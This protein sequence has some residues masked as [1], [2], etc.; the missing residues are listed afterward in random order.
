VSRRI[1][2]G[3]LLAVLLVLMAAARAD[4]HAVPQ[5]SSPADRSHLDT[6]PTSVSVTFNESV[7]TSLGGM[8]VVNCDGKQVDDGNVLARDNT[9]SVGI[10]GTLGN[11]AYVVAW[12]VISA[13]S[14]PVRGAFTFVVGQGADASDTC[15]QKNFSADSERLLDATGTVGRSLGYVGVFLAAGG[16][17]FLTLIHDGAAV[18]RQLQRIV[19]GA[20]V[21]GA[22]GVLVALPIE[23]DLAT[24]LGLTAITKGGVLSDVLADGV[25]LSTVLAL[26]GLAVLSIG[27]LKPRAR[28]ARVMTIAGAVLAPLSFAFAGHTTTTSP[29]L[30]V[31]VADAVH[32][33]AGAAWFG[34]LTFLVLTLL[35]RGKQR[36]PVALGGIVRR[37]SLIA[38]VGVLAVTIAGA[39]LGWSQVR[40][41]RALTST[42]YGR[43]LMVKVALVIPIALIGAYNHF[44]L[45]P[46]IQQ[47]A[48]RGR[49]AFRHLLRTVRI[50]SIGLVVVLVLTAA[51]VNT[52]PARTAAGIGTIFSET[53]PIGQDSVNLVVDPNRAGGNSIHLYLLDQS[54]R[55]AALAQSVELD[56]SLPSAN[57]GPI[58]RNPSVAG[59]GHY[60][61]D[62]NDL[63]IA[64][65]WT[66]VVRAQ[67]SKFEEN[68][69]NFTVNVNP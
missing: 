49:D 1:A 44:R 5:A 65:A 57:I 10:D 55:P 54:G 52:P 50:E 6:P 19:F 43:I 67:V 14:H 2:Y 32:L 61:L 20:A 11:G 3:A 62:S 68:T 16:A 29:Q 35:R 27:L 66:I 34:G 40:A 7:S 9:V 21:I 22:F 13:D 23:A 28:W 47:A 41:W 59:P 31:N 53:K 45:V 25:G 18:R 64:G 48:A 17:L 69:A 36:D 58:V 63:T 38:T 24:G 51:L 33:L 15:V 8:R 60:L 26:V 4:A 37:F 46:A 42:T 56:I 12:R 39:T 30:L